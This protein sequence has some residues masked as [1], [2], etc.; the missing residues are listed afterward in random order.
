MQQGAIIALAI[1]VVGLIY[2]AGR[3]SERIDGIRVDLNRAEKSMQ[4]QMS[5]L[6]EMLRAA[7]G[8]RRNWR[9]EDR[10]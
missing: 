6:K 8:E 9:E 4:A 3:I 10:P 5:E 7:I 2:H 1:F